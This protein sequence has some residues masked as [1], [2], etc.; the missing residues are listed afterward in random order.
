MQSNTSGQ[1][2]YTFTVSINYLKV[3]IV[4]ASKAVDILKELDI[5]K[6]AEVLWLKE[7]F[8]EIKNTF[9]GP[10][11]IQLMFYIPKFVKKFENCTIEQCFQFE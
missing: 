6:Y 2:V 4:I 3:Q 11:N 7:T 10:F 8:I 1:T 9:N 5:Q